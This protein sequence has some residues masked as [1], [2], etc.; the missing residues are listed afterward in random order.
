MY[1]S[2][3]RTIRLVLMKVVKVDHGV[4]RFDFTPPA[5]QG[6]WLMCR[7]MPQMFLWRLRVT[8]AQAK[9]LSHG[10]LTPPATGMDKQLPPTVVRCVRLSSWTSLTV[11]AYFVVFLRKSQILSQEKPYAWTALW[12]C[13]KF[14]FFALLHSNTSSLFEFQST[15]QTICAM[16]LKDQGT[17]SF[18]FFFFTS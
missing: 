1:S 9:S 16:L 10:G 15:E 12:G 18:F 11:V 14:F 6:S 2:S 7:K 3:N 4:K 13:L 5:D 17:C 8:S